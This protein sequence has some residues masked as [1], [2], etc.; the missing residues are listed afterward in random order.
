[1]SSCGA[2]IAASLNNL[3]QS[4]QEGINFAQCSKD[5][6]G[7]GYAAGMINFTTGS[8]DAWN[9]V[10]VYMGSKGYGGEFDAFADDID[11]YVKGT[12]GKTSGFSGFCTAWVKAA[13]NPSN[14][15]WNAQSSVLGSTY[16]EPAMAF[17]GDLGVSLDVTKAAIYDSAIV[18]GPDDGGSS[19]GG[20][21][22]AT[23]KGI[24][25]DIS[26]SSGNTL[27]INGK[28]KVDEIKWLQLFLKQRTETNSSD[29][30]NAASYNAIID[31][32]TYNWDS[33][34]ITALDYNGKKHTIKCPSSSD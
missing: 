16:Y 34:S 10:K 15:F 26:G 11:T 27:T 3:L 18:D 21:I 25:Q 7:N 1:M 5:N 8:G 19:V 20:I 22:D 13:D 12:G 32:G 4:G 2:Q 31:E 30:V 23:N 14:A 6:S 28:Y 17:A 24:D 33:D 29:K 9:V